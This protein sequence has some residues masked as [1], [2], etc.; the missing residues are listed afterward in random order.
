MTLY[1]LI[2][3]PTAL[4]CAG[5]VPISDVYLLSY[6]LMG[7]VPGH[8]FACEARGFSPENSCIRACFPDEMNQIFDNLKRQQN[9]FNPTKFSMPNVMGPQHGSPVDKRI[10]YQ[11]FNK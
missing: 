9:A 2:A 5:V 10:V 7:V 1:S 6:E 8:A 11:N 3:T 4:F